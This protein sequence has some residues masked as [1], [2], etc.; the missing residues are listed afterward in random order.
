MYHYIRTYDKKLPYFNFLHKKDF[1]K[2]INYFKKK[3]SI[4]NKDFE[5]I[6][7]SKGI[8][9]SFD[10]G[11][12]EH[13]KIGK[14]LFKNKLKAAFFISGYPIEKKDFLAI[15]KIHLIFGKFNSDAIFKIF[16]KFSIGNNSKNLFKIFLQQK[17]F[18]KKEKNKERKKKIILKTILNNYAQQNQKKI[19]EVFNYCFTRKEQKNMFK[20]FYLNKSDIKKLISYGMIVGAHGFSHRVLSK[21]STKVLEKD[22]NLSISILKKIIKKKTQFFCYPYG[23][24]SVFDNRV[25]SLLKKNNIRYAFNV[26][27]K[28][29]GPSSKNLEIP[30]FDCNEFKFGK[31]FK[32]ETKKQ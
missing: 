20:N 18:L 12:K 1:F 10:D 7:R 19:D 15:H 5:Q 24:K 32:Y 31:L 27:S 29:F 21:L 6:K 9:L 4:L 17:K 8:F 16:N 3:F 22:I 14:Y 11:L 23:G 13:L 30:R 2:Q 26:D 25:I 28:N